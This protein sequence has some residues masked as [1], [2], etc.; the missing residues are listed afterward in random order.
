M[1]PVQI[2][3]LSNICQKVNGYILANCKSFFF[4]NKFFC[5]VMTNEWLPSLHKETLIF[6]TSHPLYHERER[7]RER[8]LILHFW[9]GQQTSLIWVVYSN[10]FF[11]LSSYSM[12]VCVCVCVCE[13]EREREWGGLSVDSLGRF[14]SVLLFFSAFVGSIFLRPLDYPSSQS[15]FLPLKTHTHTHI[16]LSLFV[17]SFMFLLFV[18][19]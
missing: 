11:G 17:G 18:S 13:R 2:P 4:Q 15:S 7:E 3:T 10:S 16:S 9:I 5:L 1:F 8:E 19:F 6:Y 12:C 14:F